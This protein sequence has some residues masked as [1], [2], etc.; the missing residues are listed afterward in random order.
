MILHLFRRY[1]IFFVG[2]NGCKAEVS[3][4]DPAQSQAIQCCHQ[5]DQF[6]W[7]DYED[8][9]SRWLCNGCRI[10]L[11]IDI[12]SLWF[13]GDHQDMHDDDENKEN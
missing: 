7:V 8:N 11:A 9:C 10:K 5:S 2:A 6:D 3:T 1:R 13:C 12:D 4:S